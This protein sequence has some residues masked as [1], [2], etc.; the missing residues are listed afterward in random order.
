MK[1]TD[2]TK[3]TKGNNS[4]DR[5]YVGDIIKNKITNKVLKVAIVTLRVDGKGIFDYCLC[6]IDEEDESI[7]NRSIRAEAF[8]HWEL[9]APT[10]TSPNCTM[11]EDKIAEFVRRKRKIAAQ[12]VE[13]KEVKA[14][15]YKRP[16]DRNAFTIRMGKDNN[17]YVQHNEWSKRTWIGPYSD[18]VD[19]YMII[20]SY[21]MESLKGTLDKKPMDS[22]HSLVVENEKDFFV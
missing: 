22:V 4:Q 7:L 21:V 11:G 3:R 18:A 2:K 1:S 9:L 6:D 16:I 20:E 12:K 17:Y 13:I 10:F 5:F 19:A 15:W 14:P 8:S